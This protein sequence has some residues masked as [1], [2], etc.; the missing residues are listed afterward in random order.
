MPDQ[1]DAIRPPPGQASI[2]DHYMTCLVSLRRL[3]AVLH[4]Q[5]KYG[6]GVGRDSKNVAEVLDLA[7]KFRV[8]GDESQAEMFAGSRSSLD[9]VLRRDEDMRDTVL[10][11]L[12]KLNR[13]LQLCNRIADIAQER[14]AESEQDQD[15]TGDGHDAD[16]S[17][18]KI[19]KLPELLLHSSNDLNSLYEISAM[20][21]R[22][23]YERSYLRS[24][25]NTGMD[26][27]ASAYARFDLNYVADKIR[28]WNQQHRI[29]G[30]EERAVR[31]GSLVTSPTSTEFSV[32]QDALIQRLASANTK[33]RRQLLYWSDNPE[34]GL[35]HVI[36]PGKMG[37]ILSQPDRVA[38]KDS[39]TIDKSIP[40]KSSPSKEGGVTS[41]VREFSVFAR[42]DF[43]GAH[44]EGGPAFT[45]YA[46]STVGNK[47]SNR[48]P[49]LPK[50]A[51]LGES[52]ECPYC[53]ATL[54]ASKMRSRSEWKRHVFRDLRPYMCTFA[55]CQTPNKQYLTRHE[56]KHHELQM[57]RRRWVC[58]EHFDERFTTSEMLKMHITS[59]H[60]ASVPTKH[61]SIFLNMCERPIDGAENTPCPLCP[62]VRPLVNLQDH[63]AEHL[64]SIA[65]FVLI[66]KADETDEENPNSQ[67]YSASH[68]AVA[69]RKAFS[70]TNSLFSSISHESSV[71]SVATD[72]LG[73][74]TMIL[75]LERLL[76]Q[77]TEPDSVTVQRWVYA[78]SKYVH[79]PNIDSATAVEGVPFLEHDERMLHPEDEPTNR[80]PEREV[81]M[82]AAFEGIS[83]K[84]YIDQDRYRKV[85]VL[86]LHW[87]ERCDGHFQGRIKEIERLRTIFSQ[88]YNYS[89][90]IEHLGDSNPQLTL[91]W[92]ILNHVQQH[93]DKD[94]LLIVYYSGDA[95]HVVDRHGAIHLELAASDFPSNEVPTARWDIAERPLLSVSYDVLS[96]LDCSFASAA[97]LAP[98]YRDQD[99]PRVTDMALISSPNEDSAGPSKGS[100]IA[101]S[102]DFE[103]DLG[104]RHDMSNTT[105]SKIDAEDHRTRDRSYQLLAASPAESATPVPGRF[106]FTNALCVSLEDLLQE[107]EESLFPVLK[108]LERINIVRPSHPALLWDR[109]RQYNGGSIRLGKV[110]SLSNREAVDRSKPREQVALTLR[111]WIRADDLTN[112]Q[113][114]NMARVMPQ[115]FRD[116]NVPLRRAEWVRLER[117]LDQ[118]T[119]L[120]VILRFSLSRK[121]L[122]SED[123]ELLLRRLQEACQA[124]Q[125][126][127]RKVSLVSLRKRDPED[128]VRRAVEALKEGHRS[129]EVER[130]IA[131]ENLQAQSFSGIRRAIEAFRNH[132]RRF[133]TVDSTREATEGKRSNMP[134][135]WQE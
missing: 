115:V 88:S 123:I 122:S 16:Y 41:P 9:S 91:N 81:E 68:G 103:D 133:E 119:E 72:R 44:S 19:P 26:S 118:E 70:K 37:R 83:N 124:V 96:I 78:Q 69:G 62:D 47:Q 51:V 101:M 57:H 55:T 128:T 94:T 106:S 32:V 64:E 95:L 4:R 134:G 8:W 89:C 100:P 18:V 111:F 12:A 93:A 104:F 50:T 76:D 65:L 80:Q 121:D 28:S 21:R 131:K 53:G 35:K 27:E 86:L 38:A 117:R 77:I 23:G 87:V 3:I 130:A 43:L 84:L 1:N 6:S 82:M 105:P 61:L 73:A 63:L 7:G 97:A 110:I 74:E 20:I 11:I 48:V 67:T 125:I 17:D 25:D 34:Q 135:G 116:V 31:V 108:L 79:R 2:H 102:S 45:S 126:D 29:V 15:M 85:A 54:L 46:P 98:E 59:S 40:T 107:G 114:A 66:G 42:S 112:E 52:F 49:P 30:A 36:Q 39:G 56:W 90:T 71:E 60:S 113:L 129:Y 5:S 109:L 92:A 75:G 13:Q 58:E 24:T 132:R 120:S 99:L 14:E 127:V 22:P 10:G 33:R